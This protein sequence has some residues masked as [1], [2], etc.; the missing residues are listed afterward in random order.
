MNIVLKGN[1]HLR[2]LLEE[3]ETLKKEIDKK[4]KNLIKQGFG[5]E[6]GMMW[7]WRLKRHLKCQLVKQFW[8]KMRAILPV[9]WGSFVEHN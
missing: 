6:Y 4:S 3:I 5:G 7:M 1:G 8:F 9:V 2:T